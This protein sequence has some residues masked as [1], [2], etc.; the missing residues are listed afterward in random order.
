MM[1]E[2]YSRNVL[3]KWQKQG[4]IEHKHDKTPPLPPYM[5]ADLSHQCMNTN[6]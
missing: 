4:K 1:F 6:A 5:R 3:I 2:G